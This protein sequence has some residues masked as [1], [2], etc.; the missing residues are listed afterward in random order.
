MFKIELSANIFITFDDYK[1]IKSVFSFRIWTDVFQIHKILMIL[2]E[3]IFPRNLWEKFPRNLLWNFYSHCES[4]F[5]AI[6]VYITCKLGIWSLILHLS[7]AKKSQLTLINRIQNKTEEFCIMLVFK[8]ITLIYHH[9]EILELHGYFIILHAN[10]NNK[11][12]SKW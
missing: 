6:Y 11:N 7:L 12:Y 5:A 1:Y 2:E 10:F 8:K 4:Y 9:I 3:A